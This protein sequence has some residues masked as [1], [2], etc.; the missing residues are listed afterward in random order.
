MLTQHQFYVY[1]DANN[2]MA[3]MDKREPVVAKTC[4]TAQEAH[5]LVQ[6]IVNPE[7]KRPEDFKQID[8]L[9]RPMGFHSDEFQSAISGNCEAFV[10]AAYAAAA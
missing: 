9:G 3:R 7:N 1:H 6:T 10:T 4:T 8:S 5:D 2:V